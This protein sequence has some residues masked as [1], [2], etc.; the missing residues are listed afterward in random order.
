M[1][2]MVFGVR[3]VLLGTE[4][5]EVILQPEVAYALDVIP[6]NINAGTLFAFPVHCDLVVIPE[7]RSDMINVFFDNVFNSK[8][9]HDEEEHDGPPLVDPNTGGCGSLVV[10]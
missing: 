7:D 3:M 1:R 10:A 9:V 6:F 2:A 8:V 5:F 4:L